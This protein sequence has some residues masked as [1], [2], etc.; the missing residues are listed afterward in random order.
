LALPPRVRTGIDEFDKMLDGGF[1][2][3]D[4]VMLAGSAGSGKTTLALQYLVNGAAYGEHGIYLSF[5]Q[6]PDQLYRDAKNFGWDLPKLEQENKL[7]VIC[8]SPNLLV[9]EGGAEA[10]LE[11]PRKEINARRI[12]VD[13]LSHLSMFVKEEDM[14]LQLYRTLMLFKAKELSSLLLWETPQIAGQ[15]FAI[16]DT[17]TSFLV[18]AIVMLKFVEINST[19]RNAMVVMKMR[20]SRHDKHL[21]E[22]QIGSNGIK[23][24]A[25]FTDYSGLMSGSPTKNASEKFVEMFKSATKK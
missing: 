24:E 16:S 18:D 2:R 15:T 20:G 4:A 8:T 19:I 22:Y 11:E 7:K 21:R 13:S 23:V 17:G 3:G 12:V 6:L 5:E 25:A 9:E 1:M 10:L 14:R